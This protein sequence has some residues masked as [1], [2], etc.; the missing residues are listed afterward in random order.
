MTS[1]I[2]LTGLNLGLVFL[3][4]LVCDASESCKGFTV[5]TMPRSSGVFLVD[6]IFKQIKVRMDMQNV[7]ARVAIT[8]PMELRSSMASI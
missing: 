7:K 3:K 5:P 6:L 4:A 2:V 1:D 8:M